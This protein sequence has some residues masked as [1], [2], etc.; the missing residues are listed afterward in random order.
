MNPEEYF[1]Q[2]LEIEP[3]YETEG[4]FFEPFWEFM[5]RFQSL[6][7]HWQLS[8]GFIQNHISILKSVQG[9]GSGEFDIIFSETAQV[10]IEYFPEYLRLSTLSFS[11]SLVENFL[12]S[13][14][15]E[16]ANDLGV[17]LEFE[18]KKLPYI[19]KYIL[20]LT[21]GCGIDINIDSEMWKSIDAI[22]EIRNRFIHRINRDIPDDIKK[23]IS[24]MVSL[25]VEDEKAITDDFVDKALMELA[26]L[27]KTIELAYIEFYE[28]TKNG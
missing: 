19:N 11:L 21:R 22:R 15:E 8:K 7:R 3:F 1:Y 23:V 6:Q 27:I 28:K 18:N 26:K 14:S 4:I 17:K 24:E 25:A 13:L 20:W 12:G 9:D 2:L 5:Y 10:D 16:V